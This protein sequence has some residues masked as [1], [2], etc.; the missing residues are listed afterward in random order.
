[1]IYTSFWSKPLPADMIRI[2][3]SRGSPRWIKGSPPRIPALAPG[4]WMYSV[5]DF[6]HFRAAYSQQL[7]CLDA[8][9]ISDQ[10][11]RLAGGRIPVLCCFCK[12]PTSGTAYCHRSL[13]SAWLEHRLGLIV[14]EHG[15]PG[16]HG[17]FH[18]LLPDSHRRSVETA[19]APIRP[20]QLPLL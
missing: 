3:I 1:M 8:G 7:A 17:V 12:P 11:D 13:A 5:P 14:E 9:E 20:V 18:P 19:T 15:V 16:G 2:G 4:Q 10:I 6:E